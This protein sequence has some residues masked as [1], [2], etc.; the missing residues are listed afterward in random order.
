MRFRR[1]KVPGS[2]QMPS[3]LRRKSPAAIIIA[4][5]AAVVAYDRTRHKHKPTGNDAD[6]YH[7][8]VFRVTHIADGDTFDIDAADKTRRETRIRLWGVD[9]PELAHDG[10]PEMHFGP[11][12]KAFAKRTLEG[13]DVRVLLSPVRT[14]DVHE[15]LLAYVEVDGRLVNQMLIEEG[16][17]YADWRFEHAYKDDFEAAEMRAR[18]ARTGLWAEV[19]DEQMPAWRRRMTENKKS[20]A[21]KPGGGP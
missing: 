1:L 8:K 13:R 15:R 17:G 6:R 19:T 16:Y 21:E 9:T 3:R 18:A 12:A 10:E 7:G 14:R 4:L 2:I 20:K 11:Q 5:I